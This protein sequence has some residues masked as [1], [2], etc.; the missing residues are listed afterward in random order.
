MQKYIE[1]MPW[2]LLS[3]T[4]SVT[5]PLALSITDKRHSIQELVADFYDIVHSPP[6]NM[7]LTHIIMMK[8]TKLNTLKIRR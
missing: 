8:S 1:H 7:T 5:P 4:R 3:L 2:S 6:I